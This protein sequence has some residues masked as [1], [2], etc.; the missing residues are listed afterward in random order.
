MAS[1]TLEFVSPILPIFWQLKWYLIL[2]T[3]SSFQTIINLLLSEVFFF[4][5]NFDIM[6]NIFKKMNNSYIYN[7]FNRFGAFG[8]V[9]AGVFAGFAVDHTP[10]GR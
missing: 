5:K 3:L 1:Y 6:H 9:Y 4:N 7:T 10:Q 8:I 2:L